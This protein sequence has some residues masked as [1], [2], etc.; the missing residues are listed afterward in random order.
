MTQ[1][2][3]EALLD[4]PSPCIKRSNVSLSGQ[5]VCAK[6]HVYVCVCMHTQICIFNL[7]GQNIPT[8]GL[9]F[10]NINQKDT[11]LFFFPIKGAK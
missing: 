11:Y 2:F 4:V 5:C 7:K 3:G 9:L 10:V 1:C 6:L 8:H